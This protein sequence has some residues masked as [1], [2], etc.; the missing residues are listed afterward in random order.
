M[1]QCPQRIWPV[2]SKLPWLPSLLITSLKPIS[3]LK[4][5]HSTHSYMMS[6]PMNYK[7]LSMSPSRTTYQHQCTK[8][9]IKNKDRE[10]WMM[11]VLLVYITYPTI[12]VKKDSVTTSIR[13]VYDCSCQESSRSASLNDCHT[14]GPPF[15]KKILCAIQLWFRL[16]AFALSAD[17]EK[18]FLH[19]KLERN[20]TRFLWP[21]NPESPDPEFQTYHF[22]VVPFGVSSSPYA[23]SSTRPTLIEISSPNCSWHKKQRIRWQYSV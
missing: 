19:V 16:H 18:A 23:G 10:G 21:S 6:W 2:C 11:T 12:P 8:C 5:G 13:I 20:F 7:S 3:Y 1:L 4:R 9:H 15:K 22:T 17:I 14:T